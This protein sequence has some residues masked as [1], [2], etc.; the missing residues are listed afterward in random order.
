MNS[1]NKDLSYMFAL[2]S[3]VID[4]GEIQES[5]RQVGVTISRGEAENLLKR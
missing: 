2:F 5:F 3:G 1:R 4:A